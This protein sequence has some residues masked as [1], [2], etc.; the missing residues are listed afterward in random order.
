MNSTIKMAGVGAGVLA[1]SAAALGGIGLAN[2]QDSGSGAQSEGKHR[3]PHGPKGEAV[4]GDIADQAKAAAEEAVPGGTAYRVFERRDG[5]YAVGMSKADSGRVVVLLN[6]NFEPEEVKDLPDRGGKGDKGELVTGESA[7]QA[8]AAAEAKV[9]GGTAYRVFERPDGGYAVGMTNADGKPVVVLLDDS[10]NYED[11]KEL[12]ERRKGPRGVPVTGEA[13]D[14]ASAAALD[15][16]EKGTVK[17]VF[18]GHN[19]GYA[20]VVQMP[21]D[22]IRKVLLD[23]EFSVEKV[24]SGKHRR[25]T[26]LKGTTKQKAEKAALAEVPGEA[27]RSAKRDGKFF[28]IVRT[29]DGAVGVKMNKNFKV[30]D[31]KE[32][33]PRERGMRGPG[34]QGPGD[35]SAE[36]ASNV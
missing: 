32:L 11:T 27:V 15:Y 31:T 22:K 16:L 19:D 9:Q 20:V 23:S 34:P 10:F 13:A 29:D 1:L 18:E 28:V 35:S 21:N 24:V 6:D 5:G 7:D 2:A 4:T 26:P 25:G 14:S 36:T 33:P 8:T 12:P 17:A 30:K 3:G